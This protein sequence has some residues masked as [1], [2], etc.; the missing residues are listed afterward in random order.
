MVIATHEVPVDDGAKAGNTEI[1][2]HT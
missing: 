2:P 1:V